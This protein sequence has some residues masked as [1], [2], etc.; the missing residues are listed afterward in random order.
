MPDS[1]R[2]IPFKFKHYND[3]VYLLKCR[4]FE[5]VSAITYKSLPKTGY[6][7]YFGKTAIAAGFIRRIEP[8]MCMFDSFTSNPFMGSQLRNNALTLIINN[9]LEDAKRLK[10]QSIMAFTHDPGIKNRIEELKFLNTGYQLYIKP[11]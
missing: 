4:G 7:A 2:I 3:L 1:I 10:L 9:L 5:Q 11:L 6:I 8:N